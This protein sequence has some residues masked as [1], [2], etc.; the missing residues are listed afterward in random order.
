MKSWR[1]AELNEKWHEARTRS[2]EQEDTLL[3]EKRKVSAER[4]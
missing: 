4:F 2:R 1:E 3:S